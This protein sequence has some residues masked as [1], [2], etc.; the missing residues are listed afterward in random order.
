MDYMIA[1]DV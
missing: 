1:Y